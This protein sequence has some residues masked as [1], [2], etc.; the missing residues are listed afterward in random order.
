VDVVPGQAA[1]APL[2]EPILEATCQRVAV[3]DEAV[4]DKGFDSD[5]IREA[6]VDRDIAAVI[7]NRTNR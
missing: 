3:I 7:P 6:C 4:G 5:A 1:D 2:F